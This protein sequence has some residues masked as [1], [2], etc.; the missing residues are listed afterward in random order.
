MRQALL[1]SLTAGGAL[2]LALGMA[3]AA[4]A[5][6]TFTVTVGGSTFGSYSLA[7]D[8]T[9]GVTLSAAVTYH[10]SGAH[11]DGIVYAGSTSGKIADLT[12]SDWYGCVGPLGFAL[13][14]QQTS[15]WEVD[16]TNGPDA[17]GVVQARITNVSAHIEDTSTDGGE[18]AFDILGST[19]ATFTNGTQTLALNDT[20]LT[21]SN[22]VGCFGLIHDPAGFLGSFRITDPKTY[23][24]YPITI[25]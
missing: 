18:C 23:G 4:V 24:A 13:T 16:A 11:F 21:V 1:R 2:A 20:D 15:T 22:V 14:V 17:N 7:G 25:S 12:A 10:C 6:P 19:P 8:S 9:N 5:G 3:T